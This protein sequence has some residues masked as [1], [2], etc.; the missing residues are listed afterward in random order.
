MIFK[1]ECYKKAE[2]R[3]ETIL[4][5]FMTLDQ[6][7]KSLEPIIDA[8]ARDNWT[9]QNKREAI[10]IHDNSSQALTFIENFRLSNGPIEGVEMLEHGFQTIH[11]ELEALNSYFL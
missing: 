4:R 1:Q 5:L 10:R 11:K 2:T 8:L 3:G 7:N 9:E 6:Q